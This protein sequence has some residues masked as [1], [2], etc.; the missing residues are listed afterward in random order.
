MSGKIGRRSFLDTNVT[1][2]AVFSLPQP[3]CNRSCVQTIGFLP[4]VHDNAFQRMQTNRSNEFHRPCAKVL[5]A[6]IDRNSTRML[7]LSKL[8]FYSGRVELSFDKKYFLSNAFP[9]PVPRALMDRHFMMIVLAVV[10]YESDSWSHND[11]ILLRRR[12]HDGVESAI[13]A[14]R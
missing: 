1:P 8:M 10:M 4:R 14:S 5:T 3:Q 7:L 13:K 11:I 2:E 12:N 6:D 9:P